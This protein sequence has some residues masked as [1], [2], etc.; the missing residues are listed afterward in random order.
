MKSLVIF[1]VFLDLFVG[2]AVYGQTISIVDPV[3]KK[4]LTY[5]EI[6]V[7]PNGEK[8][9]SKNV[10]GGFII[11]RNQKF[12]KVVNYSNITPK[13]YGAKGNGI[14]QNSGDM[15]ALKSG[16][17]DT[18]ALAVFFK[19]RQK[20]PAFGSHMG[21]SSLYVPI[22][23]YLTSGSYNIDD[24]FTKIFGDGPGA[25]IIHAIA[26]KNE[27]VP[28]FFFGR[29]PVGNAWDSLLTG[30]GVNNMQI[31]SENAK[32]RNFGII[33]DFAEYMN[34]ENLG[35]RN[36]GKSAVKGNFWESYFSN[37]KIES[38]GQNQT[39][40]ENGIPDTGIIDF[41]YA[42][43][44]PHLDA[45]NNGYFNKITFSSCTG[46]LIKLAAAA[47]TT[48]NINF[49]GLYAETY[50]GNTGKP[51]ELPLIYSINSQNNSIS[52]GFITVNSSGTERNG[53][54][55]L[56]D[57]NSSLSVSNFSF[58]MNPVEGFLKRSVRRLNSFGRIS[59]GSTLSLNSV[60]F[61]DPT[62]SVGFGTSSTKPL[63]Y[64]KGKLLMN[65]VQFHVLDINSGGTRRLTNLVDRNLKADGSILVIPYDRNGKVQ[66]LQKTLQFNDGKITFFYSSVP[67]TVDTW[68]KGDRIQYSE[69][70]NRALG[71]VCTEPGTTGTSRNIMV[72]GRKGEKSVRALST[73]N[74]LVGDWIVF[75]GM[76]GYNRISA[77]SNKEILLEQPLPKNLSNAL[78][79]FKPPVWETFQTIIK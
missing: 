12:Y 30:G 20:T 4:V 22:S 11:E 19:N 42:T 32:I 70:V 74:L 9:T 78:L 45:S 7:L 64:G 68:E 66:A 75:A 38:S 34:F 5:E 25:T 40:S 17:D 37:V 58:N 35:F 31:N 8:I 21:G 15:N 73:E 23:V 39:G 53:L 61:E 14:Y 26:A 67:A 33:L 63:L 72:S 77:I 28:V 2:T 48:V 6:D 76:E 47:N 46:T 36:L 57:G 49:N 44:N 51:E 62:D 13:N 18:Q 3:S 69:P 50:P 16:N 10:D 27:N 24:H 60:N 65:L 43:E 29:K 41:S 54:A 55:L 1:L 52:H 59:Y 79:S 71:L 56:L